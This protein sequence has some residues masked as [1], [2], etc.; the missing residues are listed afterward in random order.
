[1]A[2]RGQKHERLIGLYSPVIS[3]SSHINFVARNTL[4]ARKRLDDD[5]AGSSSELEWELYFDTCVEEFRK[6]RQVASDAI[7]VSSKL[8]LETDETTYHV[9][10][11]IHDLS[12]QL[13]A[14]AD[15][16]IDQ[17]GNR[18]V[19]SIETVQRL[20]DEIEALNSEF[21]R[22]I[23]DHMSEVTATIPQKLR[24]KL[25]RTSSQGSNRSCQNK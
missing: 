13:Y 25:H 11:R 22:L 19:P 6:A 15:A 2:I 7:A 16:H 4:E 20:A 5:K 21:V 14:L 10:M 1:M 18:R 8:A 24:H 12:H 9:V 3:A 17:H 23:A